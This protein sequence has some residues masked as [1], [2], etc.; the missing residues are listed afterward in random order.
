MIRALTA[1][2]AAPLAAGCAALL[3]AGCAGQDE[4]RASES[5]SV[6]PSA[7]TSISPSATAS[8]ASA[9]PSGA[10]GEPAVDKPERPK[11]GSC[12]RLTLEEAARPTNSDRP[13]LC[14]KHHTA[15]TI[16]V[17]RLA[18]V[19]DGHSLGVDSDQVQAQL[20]G[21]C[22]RKLRSFLGGGGETRALSRFQV[23]WFSPT[24]QEYDAGAD[25]F[26]CDV[27]A[28]AGPDELL[29]LP[30]DQRL[31]GV[32]DRPG[33]LA[34]YGTCGTAQPGAKD[35]QRVA[36]ALRHS[37]V[38][39]ST[40]PISGGNRYP[41][42]AAVRRAGEETC[43]DQVRSRAG[44]PLKYSYGWEWP[45]VQQWAGGQHFGFCWAPAG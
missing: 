9:T 29:R 32:L 21:T 22:P 7:S 20:R 8:S 35:F 34:T 42:V 30:S 6:S 39:I 15:R 11:K 45:T 24:V 37:W 3:L 44:L 13:V 2:L 23:V 10:T 5:S 1:P 36:C 41:G 18:T 43:S 19:V 38:A 14:T 4:P 27:V 17:G 26:R 28:V 31:R 25:W 40:I 33:A 12:Y 16:Y